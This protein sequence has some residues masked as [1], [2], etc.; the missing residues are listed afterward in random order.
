M[1][2]G[3]V[4]LGKLGLPLLALL[5]NSNHKVFGFDISTK[6]LDTLRNQECPYLEPDLA[7]YL[8]SGWEN[9]EL[10]SSIK[11]LVHETEICMVIVPT[12]SQDNG[13]F[14]NGA[15]IEICK[16]IGLALKESPKM[17][18]VN[19]VSTVM[20]GSCDGEIKETLENASGMKVG[21][22]LGVCY[23]PEFIALGS[24]IKDMQYPDMHLLGSNSQKHADRVEKLLK[25]ISQKDVPIRRMSCVEAELVKISVNNFVTMK[26][27]FANMLGEISEHLGGLNIDIVTDAIGLDSRVGSK[28]LKAGAPY[29]GPCFPRDT[30]ALGALLND[31]GIE[32]SLP[33]VVANANIAHQGYLNK[34]VLEKAGRR[35]I[36]V[37]GLS[38]K[39]YTPVIEESPGINLLK[40][41]NNSGANAYGWDP[42]VKPSA[43][44]VDSVR[45]I[46]S[47]EDFLEKIEVVVVTRPIPDVDIKHIKD[48]ESKFE[49]IDFWRQDF[50]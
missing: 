22:L 6:L 33:E 4:G 28:Y 20:P 7:E 16:N 42:T 5:A 47:L 30:R 29:G 3:V 39:P 46:D 40:F 35:K 11:Q 37:L 14:D 36:G 44:G 38:Y 2:V 18:T 32:N 13:R 21:D 25:D 15:I 19:I 50:N 27:A 24:V 49:V 45:V 48:I 34:T 12:P 31:Y 17:F 10:T 23:N 26:I 43:D 41:L 8:N 1:N 9:I